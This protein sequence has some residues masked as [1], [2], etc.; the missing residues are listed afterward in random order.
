MLYPYSGIVI[1]SYN[2][3]SSESFERKSEA[4]AAE[5][6]LAHNN[7]TAQL[8]YQGGSG[9]WELVDGNYFFNKEPDYEYPLNPSRIIS[10]DTPPFN[11]LVSWL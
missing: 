3:T 10:I 7:Y 8:R 9:K 2:G 4:E 1:M 11:T 5:L 6:T